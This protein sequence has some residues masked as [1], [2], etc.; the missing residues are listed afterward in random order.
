MKHISVRVLTS[1][2]LQ[3][4]RIEIIRAQKETAACINCWAGAAG[5]VALMS[6]EQTNKRL[7]PINHA[8]FTYH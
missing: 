3:S 6:D 8:D 7:T 1:F 5:G 4:I 2:F